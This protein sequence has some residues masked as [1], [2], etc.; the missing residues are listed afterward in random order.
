MLCLVP[1]W[2]V[3]G[4]CWPHTYKV[5]GEYK[6]IHPTDNPIHTLTHDNVPMESLILLQ[7]LMILSQSG[8]PLPLVAD[9][10]HNTEGEG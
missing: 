9:T 3:L 10:T 5:T 1:W 8:S 6:R 4:Q 7:S 2:L